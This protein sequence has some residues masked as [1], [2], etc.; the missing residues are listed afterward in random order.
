M[1]QFRSVSSC[2]GLMASTLLQRWFRF[3][4]K[5]WR[6]LNPDFEIILLD[7]DNLHLYFDSSPFE[8]K[9]SQLLLSHKSDIIRL[10]LL[11]NHGGFWADAT[12]VCTRPLAEWLDF[13]PKSGVVFLRTPQG[14]NRFIQNFFL[15]SIPRARF[16][17]HWLIGLLKVHLSSAKAMTNGTL[18]RWRR[19]RPFLWGSSLATS[20]W[21]LRP[22]VKI[23]GYPYLVAHYVANR[24]ILFSWTGIRAYLSSANYRAGEILHL[25]MNAEGLKKYSD[26][27]ARGD[28][29]LWKLSWRSYV[30]P[31]FWDSAY[32]VTKTF[33]DAVANKK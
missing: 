5:S 17:Q 18:K 11:S 27:L 2:I 33:V 32:K 21:S 25:G 20:I 6:E 28:F 16:T 3:S 1:N 31:E 22:I 13:S 8:P 23:T 30:E 14:K 24:I 15:G 29:P 10:S 4:V 7:D 26:Q 9:W 19:R 12:L